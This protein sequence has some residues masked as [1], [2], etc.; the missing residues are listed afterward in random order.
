M[1]NETVVERPANQ[2]TLT[3][4]YTNEAIRFVETHRDEPFFLYLAHTMPHVPLFVSPE[5]YTPD[6]QRAYEATIAEIDASVGQ[7]LAA[8]NRLGLDERTLVVY[9]SDNGP[10]LSMKHHGGSAGPLR[11]GK[12]QTFEGGMR[13]PCVMYWPGTIPAGTECDEVAST[14]D[15]L[16]TLAGLAGAD[17]PADRTI[18]GKDIAP[19]LRGEP[20]ARSPHELYCYYRGDE[21][22]A[23][24]AGRWKL[25]RTKLRPSTDGVVPVELY[26]LEADIAESK[27]MASEEPVV[28]ARLLETM[29]AYDAALQAEARPL[30]VSLSLSYHTI[31][32]SAREMDY[33]DL[34]VTV[35]MRV[36]ANDGPI[37]LRDEATGEVIAAQ[38]DRIGSRSALSFVVD[39]LPA[40]TVRRYR[41]E[42]GGVEGGDGESTTKEGVELRVRG[43]TLDVLIDG[44]LFTTYHGEGG[45]RPYCW[46]VIGPTG[47]SVTRNFPMRAGVP[48]ER[49]DH[50]HHQS[51]WFGYDQVNGH[52]FWRAGKQRTVHKEFVS[53]TSGPAFGE[54]AARV[55]WVPKGQRRVVCEDVRRF[56]VW[57]T[58][59]SRVVDATIDLRASS[60]PVQ[61]GDSEEGMFAFRVA[62]SMKVDSG[63]TIRNAAGQTNRDAWG[64]RSPW[65]DYSG[66]LEG[67]TVGVA[68]LDHPGNLRHPTYWHVRPYGLFCANRFGVRDFTGEGDGSHRIPQGKSLRQRYRVYIHRGDALEG[69]VADFYQGYTR[70]PQIALE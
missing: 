64:K 51:F 59:A 54:F 3:E 10:W 68:I 22:E 60:G 6:P 4:R 49:K 63:G 19:L 41:V 61:L 62:G 32:L 31:V 13:E 57:R 47:K 53:L 8:L 45:E 14:I 23:A 69:R 18:D 56:R 70:A 39:S 7:L 42:R 21:L 25:R 12:F 36:E 26:D 34:P 46:P 40:G 16:P 48:G 9:T 20:D 44:E 2:L 28:A 30:G 5:F 67:E 52:D 27:D 35:R 24:R 33:F 65:C 11:G 43:D 50:S 1:R 66:A 15:L 37:R 29:D 17:L 58:R 55:A 38:R